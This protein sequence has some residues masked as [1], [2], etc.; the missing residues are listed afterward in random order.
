MVHHALHVA[1]IADAGLKLVFAQNA[2][3]CGRRGHHGD[4]HD[5][6]IAGHHVTALL[7]SGVHR[8]EVDGGLVIADED[9][10]S[11]TSGQLIALHLGGVQE[12]AGQLGCQPYNAVQQG[13]GTLEYGFCLFHSNS[14]S[15]PLRRCE[16][17][18]AN[19]THP[20]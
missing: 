11:G 7:H 16:T 15:A 17:D 9:A 10:P 3:P 19:N 12:G 14:F 6:G 20:Y 18:L 5:D 13:V 4:G 8:Q 1:H 2:H